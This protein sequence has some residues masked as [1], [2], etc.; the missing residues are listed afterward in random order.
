MIT[1]TQK[2]DTILFCKD[3]QFCRPDPSH[4]GDNKL[5]FAKCSTR[6]SFNDDKIYTEFLVTGKLNYLEHAHYCTSMREEHGRND[7]LIKNLKCGPEARYFIADTSP[8]PLLCH[9]R[10]TRWQRILAV[11]TTLFTRPRNRTAH[12]H[13]APVGNVQQ[14][15]LPAPSDVGMVG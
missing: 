10:M 6:A 8:I 12:E 15:T 1:E 11:V 5:K 3:C 13:Q 4:R 9:G 14:Q 2:P 7:A